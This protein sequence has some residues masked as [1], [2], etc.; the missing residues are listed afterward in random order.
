MRKELGRTLGVCV[1]MFCVVMYH[2]RCYTKYIKIQ[3]CQNIDEKNVHA[4]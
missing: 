2:C 4:I 3:C 1:Q